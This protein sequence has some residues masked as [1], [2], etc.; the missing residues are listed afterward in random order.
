MYNT[1]YFV[2]EVQV[3]TE[4]SHQSETG[5]EKDYSH[6]RLNVDFSY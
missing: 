1:D 3:I 4:V 6:I 5:N 2:C